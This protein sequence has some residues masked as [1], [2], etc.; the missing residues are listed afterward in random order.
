MTE[1]RAPI[2]AA[3]PAAGDQD[4]REAGRHVVDLCAQIPDSRPAR[5]DPTMTRHPIRYMLLIVAGGVLAACAESTPP[6]SEPVAVRHTATARGPVAEVRIAPGTTYVVPRATQPDTTFVVRIEHDTRELQ[7]TRA[8]LARAQ[9]EL[10]ATRRALAQATGQLDARTRALQ[11]REA[12]LASRTEALRARERELAQRVAELTARDQQLRA[13]R[14]AREQAQR[15]RDTALARVREIA[16]VREEE[17][18]LVIS[19]AGPVMFRDDEATL[20]PE[21]RA[22]LDRVADALKRMP[23]DRKI[24]IEG[25][26]DA[27]GTD[28]YNRR[29]SEE[30]ANA[31]RSYLAQRGVAPERVVAMGR[32]EEDPIAPN[33]TAEGRANNRRVEIVIRPS[34]EPS[35]G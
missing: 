15:E 13:E 11:Q 10:A 19:L 35:A 12:E 24:V 16:K 7:A 9:Q 22:Q 2:R 26:A 30:R 20:L 25:H 34:R 32:G 31:V 27:R 29:L 33:R 28:E 23:P 4:V 18:G 17:R 14:E 21:A 5:G 3:E 1:S 6:P 8:E